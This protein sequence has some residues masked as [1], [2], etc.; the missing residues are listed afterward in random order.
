LPQVPAEF[1]RPD[2]KYP[3]MVWMAEMGLPAR[4]AR[5]ILQ[6]WGESLGVEITGTDYDLVSRGIAPRIV[7]R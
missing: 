7:T 3:L 1:L 4:M 5:Q 2:Q 6:Q